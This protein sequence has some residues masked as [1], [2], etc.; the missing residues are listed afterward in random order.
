MYVFSPVTHIIQSCF[1]LSDSASLENRLKKQS[2]LLKLFLEKASESLYQN[3]PP[4]FISE[5]KERIK[6][7]N[8]T[9]QQKEIKDYKSN[10]SLISLIILDISCLVL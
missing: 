4:M 2:E 10:C 5:N 9:L 1:N 8:K 7:S 6:I 3:V